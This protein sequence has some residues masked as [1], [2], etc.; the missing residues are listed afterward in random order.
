MSFLGGSMK[1]FLIAVVCLAIA[2]PAL[3]QTAEEPASKDDVIL[4]LRTMRS[5]DVMQRTMEALVKPMREMFREES[6]NEKGKLPP[7]FDAHMSKM[8]EEMVKGMPIDEMTQAMIPVYQKHFTSSDVAALNTF[9]SSPV[10]QKFLEE[11]PAVT[12]ESMQAMM[13]VMKK[14]MDGWKERMQKEAD[15]MRKQSSK[16]G[17]DAPSSKN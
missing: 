15:Q 12:G 8:M 13:P 6:M 7:D 17:Q 16:S 3:A 2:A 10:G 1:H 11:T 4:L 5:H 9:Y 14:Y